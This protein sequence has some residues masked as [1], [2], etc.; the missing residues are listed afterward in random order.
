MP[1]TWKIIYGLAVFSGIRALNNLYSQYSKV[2]TC[3]TCRRFTW[4]NIQMSAGIHPFNPFAARKK[5]TRVKWF[6]ADLEDFYI[7]VEEQPLLTAEQE[8]Q[9]GKAIRMWQKVEQ[10]RLSMAA[11]P[12]CGVAVSNEELAKEIGCSE[13]TL[14]KMAD[15]AG[16]SKERLINCNLK[17]VLAIVSRYRTSAISNSELIAEGTRGLARAVLRYDHSKGFRFAT[18]GTWYVHQAVSE[19]VRSKKHLAKMPTRYLLLFRK[20]KEMTRRYRREYRLVPT[21]EELCATFKQSPFEILKVLSMQVY[22]AQL[23]STVQFRSSNSAA[24]EKD[25]HVDELMASEYKSPAEHTSDR[26]L[27]SDMETMMQTNLNDAERD[28]LRLR[29]GL[30]D[31]RVKPIK[32]VGRRFKISWKQVRSLERGA[33]VKLLES[34][35]LVEFT[36]GYH[37]D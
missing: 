12:G 25:R 11:R 36:R 34:N 18:Y 24:P 1:I 9:Y 26:S 4:T 14:K 23:G 37:S 6:E 28:V 32:E 21:I 20:I 33:L 2:S 17:L 10:L 3:N 13:E 27:R 5:N 30:D 16:M 15:Y 31:G 8:F 7:F 19:Y 29:L 35:E 22:P